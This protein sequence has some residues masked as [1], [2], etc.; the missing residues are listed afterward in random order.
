MVLGVRGR[1]EGCRSQILVNA[2]TRDERE[3]RSH[4]EPN[5]IGMLETDMQWNNHDTDCTGDSYMPVS[6]ARSHHQT[7]R[8]RAGYIAVTTGHE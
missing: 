4:T 6:V 7:K 1:S 2:Q 5:E 3:K 8:Q